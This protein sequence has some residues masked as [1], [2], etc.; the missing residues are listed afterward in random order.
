MKRFGSEIAET[1]AL[2]AVEVVVAVE[3]VVV[4]VVAIRIATEPAYLSQGL[5]IFH[6]GACLTLSLNISCQTCPEANVCLA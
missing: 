4:V 2:A 3:I 1:V 6:S 5:M